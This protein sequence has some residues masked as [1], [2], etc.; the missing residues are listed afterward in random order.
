MTRDLLPISNHF[1]AIVRNALLDAAATKSPVMLDRAIDA[2]VA[3]YPDLLFPRSINR[4]EFAPRE[5]SVDPAVPPLGLHAG[6]ARSGL[7]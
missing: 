1:P 3:L 2:A 4:A 7:A 5:R 6:T